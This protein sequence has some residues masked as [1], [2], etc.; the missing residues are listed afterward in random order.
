MAGIRTE[1]RKYK[2]FRQFLRNGNWSDAY[3][4]I[5]SYPEAQSAIIANTGSTALHIVILAGH[6]SIVKE[7]VNMLPTDKLL[8]IKDKDGNTVLGYCA[9]VGTTKMAECIVDK[10]PN[11]LGIANGPHALI[12]VV[13]ALKRNS[14]SIAMARYLFP[15]TDLKILSPGKGSNGAT[16]VTRC[17]YSKA[18]GKNLFFF[19][20]FFFKKMVR[21]LIRFDYKLV[22]II[23]WIKYS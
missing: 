11:L 12:P 4:F 19:F 7:L 15:E 16:F 5:K 23:I 9:L 18:F 2:S 6:Q 21:N 22:I 13:M 20:F 10:C 8:E 17:I 1:L 3:R 14:N